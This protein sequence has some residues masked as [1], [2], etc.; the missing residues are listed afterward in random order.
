[1]AELFQPS[2]AEL[3]DRY[4]RDVRLAA[5]DAGLTEPATQPGSDNYLTGTAIAGLALLAFANIS[6]AETASSVLD[7]TGEDLDKI[8]EAAGLVAVEP[9]QASGKIVVTIAGATT[10]TNGTPLTLPNGLAAVVVGTYPGPADQSEVDVQVVEPGTAGNLAAGSTVRFDSPPV[11]VATDAKVSQGFPLRGGTDEEDDARKRD[12][13]FNAYRNRPGGGNWGQ[14]R[15]WA[16]DATPAVQDAYAYPALGGP[17]SCKI[18]VARKYDF[19]LGDYSRALD[20]VALQTVR[21]YI[22]S[23]MP[24][25]QEIVIQTVTDEPLYATLKVTLPDAAQAGG[26]GQGWTDALVWPPTPTAAVAII[27]VGLANDVIT[28]DASTGTSAVAGQTHI[29]W[30]SSVD[31]KFYTRLVTAVSGGIDAWVLTLDSPLIAS[32]GSGPLVGEFVSPGAYKLEAYADAWMR[33]FEGFGPAENTSDSGRLPRARRHPYTTD[34]DP[35]DLTNA[36]IGKWASQFT[37]ISG[38]SLLYSNLTT[39]TVASVDDPPN[40]LVPLNFGIYKL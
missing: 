35:S 4:L 24:V 22:Q 6:S 11:N 26:N 39:P 10:I 17:G 21:S 36:T 19:D 27:A 3:R 28:V 38:Y 20:S 40:V 1:M 16:L 34:E 32:T 14:L 5:F 23:K 18:V 12:R 8:R 13:I 37:E 15:Q 31:R 33:T 25:P 30:W 7:A 9:S 2:L 29:A